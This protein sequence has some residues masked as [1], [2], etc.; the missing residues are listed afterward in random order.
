MDIEQKK[1]N[2]LVKVENNSIKEIGK[3][4]IPKIADGIKRIGKITGWGSIAVIGL[5]A[6]AIGNAPVAAVGLIASVG[7]GTRAIQNTLYKTE[8]SLM[9]M[10]RVKHGERQIFQDVRLN[11]AS[12]MRGYSAS[13][14]AGMMGLQTLVGFSRYKDNLKNSDYE[15]GENG[16][17]VYCQKISTV[18]HGINLKNLQMLENLGYIKIDSME[19]KFRQTA[20]E[21]ALGREPRGLKNL[22]ILEKIG[23]RNFDDLKKITKAGLTGDKDT[24]DS[25]RKT[26]Q[27]VTFRLTDKQI[28]FEELYMKSANL[29][30]VEDKKE[31]TA[32]RRLSVIFDKKQGILATKNIDIGKDSFGRAVIKYDTKEPF[33]KRLDGTIRLDESQKSDIKD[34]LKE[35]VNIE[36]V[37]AKHTERK[38]IDRHVSKNQGRE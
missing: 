6:F 34:R 38:E 25:M 4:A 33:G 17:K 10:S 20:I 19:E 30:Q 12:H 7:S 2:S 3:S 35:E 26:F 8:P 37:L 23:F 18:T 22:L 15:I 16:E 29:S 31:K 21:K 24:L 1:S 27:K 5:G 28:D 14:K 9:F 32:L 13:E 36:E 11:L